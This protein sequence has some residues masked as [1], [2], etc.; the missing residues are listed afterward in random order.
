VVGEGGVLG[1]ALVDQ[2]DYVCFTGSTATGRTVAARAGERLVGASLELGGKNPFYVAD[3]AHVGLAAECAVRSVVASAGQLCMSTER[4][5]VHRDVRERF[6]E[7]FLA[8]MDAVRL[9]AGLDYHADMGSMVSQDQLDTVVRHV[10]DAVE[11]GATVLSGGRARPDVGPLFHEP[12]VLA[13]VPPTARCW[14]EET[15]GPVVSVVTVGSDDEAVQV[16]NDTS[17]GLH[18]NVWT[19]DTAR[20]RR[21][22]ARIEAGTVSVNESYLATWAAMGAP[23]GGRKA[24][25]LGRR[26]GREGITRFTQSQTIAVQHGTRYGVGLGRLL[27]LP[28]G[29]WTTAM[30]ATLRVMKRL[31][32][33]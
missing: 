7:A 22:A 27:D 18:A 6:L 24:S 17:Y 5:I 25:G 3:D 32:A 21:V 8:R 15:F 1:P 28:G 33:S 29:T 19:R 14:G 16:A 31:G 12:T 23:M 10:A 4:L 11:A 20:G 9:G 13:D 26:H 2:V 30:T